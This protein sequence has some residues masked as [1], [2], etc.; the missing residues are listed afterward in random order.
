MSRDGPNRKRARRLF[1][2]VTDEEYEAI[3]LR[4]ERCHYDNLGAYARR[5][6][7]DGGILVVDDKEEIKQ[8]TYELNKIGTNIN[9]IAH[10][11]NSTGCVSASSIEELKEMMM[12]IW[13][14]QRSIL[15][16][17]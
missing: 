17:L 2:N 1:I 5:M 11:A 3:K 14:Y 6:M 9:Q 12:T 16:G 4:M 15:C 13:Q 7:I 10:L 8:F